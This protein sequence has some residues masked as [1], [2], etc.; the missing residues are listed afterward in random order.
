MRILA[1]RQENEAERIR[2]NLLL[3]EGVLVIT[4]FELNKVASLTYNEIVC[5]ELFE[6]VEKI[7]AFPARFTPLCLHKTLVVLK[8]MLIYGSEKCVNSA[9][10]IGKFIETLQKY[11]TV[12]LAQQ[13]RGP[14]AVIQ[15][16]K[17]GGVDKGEP[18]REVAQQLQ[19]LLNNIN[20]LQRIRNEHANK[21][22]L[23]PVGTNKVGFITDEV[24]LHVLQKRMEAQQKLELKSNLAKAEGG[25]GGGYNAADGKTVVGAAHGIEE[26][27]K[28]ASKQK[29]K[30]SDDGPTGETEEE[31]ILKELMAE[32]A[33]AKKEAEAEMKK[34]Q[35][36][37]LLGANN[38]AKATGA[39]DLLDFGGP[40]TTTTPSGGATGDLLG[41]GQDLLG[42]FAAAP[43]PAAASMDPFSLGSSSGMASGANDLLGG[44]DLLGTTTTAVPQP[45]ASSNDPFGSHVLGMTP[46]DG[47]G[48]Q[49][50]DLLGA[51][52]SAPA[53]NAVESSTQAPSASQPNL[54]S[55]SEKKDEISKL[56]AAMVTT[57]LDTEMKSE[58]SKKSI[59]ASNEDRFAALD[60]LVSQ[61][62]TS[63]VTPLDMKNAENRIL[64]YVGDSNIGSSSAAPTSVPD[65]PSHSM[66][67]FC[68]IICTS[69]K[70][71]LKWS[72]WMMVFHGWQPHK[73]I[74]TLSWVEY[75]KKQYGVRMII[76]WGWLVPSKKIGTLRPLHLTKTPSRKPGSD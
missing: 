20:E 53:N 3:D 48:L 11:N 76:K 5:D 34:A 59:M 50:N 17:G 41:G 62:G 24:R 69:A 51:M 65:P 31:K 13:R 45:M 44:G 39:V 6:V 43:A 60:D 75:G 73:V 47:G 23:V 54:I 42:A 18:V 2:K 38:N 74:K 32:A 4:T 33:A 15:R 46:L 25:F 10:G 64:G 52:S 21:D 30:F 8:H 14:G 71:L 27:M 26:M 22:L 58:T 61:E 68:K 1:G 7:I 70:C 37:D 40:A 56:G 16:L 67:I 29:K 63:R 35:Q 66:L 36:A 19:V 72:L 12:L 55:E 49:S 57:K 9:Y 28:M